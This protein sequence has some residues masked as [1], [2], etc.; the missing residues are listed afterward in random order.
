MPKQKSPSYIVER[1]GN[2][3]EHHPMNRAARKKALKTGKKED[4][5]PPKLYPILFVGEQD[6]KKMYLRE[7]GK[8]YESFKT[9]AG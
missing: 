5:L 8:R 4:D 9:K 2:T 3:L 1:N 7:D 6:G